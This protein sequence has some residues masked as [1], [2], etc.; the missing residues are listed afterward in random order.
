MSWG[1]DWKA[2]DNCDAL[3]SD[4]HYYSAVMRSPF[5]FFALL[6]VVREGCPKQ[7]RNWLHRAVHRVRRNA[8]RHARWPRAPKIHFGSVLLS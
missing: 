2:D 7:E 5:I 6:I 1:Y 8:R 4:G 3:W